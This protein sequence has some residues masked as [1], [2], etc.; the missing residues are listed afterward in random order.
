MKNDK[1]HG[2]GV[3]TDSSGYLYEGLYIN[4]QKDLDYEKKK[5]KAEKEEKLAKAKVEK[6]NK[7]KLQSETKCANKAGK[8]SNDFAAKKIYESCMAANK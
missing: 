3:L 5:I 6:E 8:A 2:M 4:G 1:Y 7:M